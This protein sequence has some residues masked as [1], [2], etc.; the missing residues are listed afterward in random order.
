MSNR[1]GYW[2]NSS[3]LA[4]AGDRDPVEIITQ[5]A[6]TIVLNFAEEGNAGPPFDPFA[7]AE[8]LKIS[9][10]PREDIRDARTIHATGGKFVIEF[11]PNQPRGR[12]RY[13][14]AH[15]IIHT[16][17]PDCHE[18]VRN[19]ATH[20]AMKDDE[21]Q[22]EM[23]CNIG[24]A[25]L[26]MP[27][28][29]F[30]DLEEQSLSIDK[31]LELRKKY[32]VSTEAL[33]LRF[34]KLTKNACCV[35]SASRKESE[36]DHYQID[37][38]IT[39]KSFRTALPSGL[40]LPKTSV[41]RECTAIGFTAKAVESWVLALGKLNVECVGIPPY[42]GKQYPRV[43][44]VIRSDKER[45]SYERKLT[46][47]KGD[48]MMPRGGDNRIIAHIVNDKTPRWGAGFG[49]EIRKKWP[50]VQEDFLSWASLHGAALSLGDLHLSKVDS[51]LSVA[52]MICQH[53]YGPSAKPRIRYKA[54]K[55]CLDKL[56][57]IAVKHNASIHMPRIG[58]GQAGGS[59]TVVWELIDEALCQR[60]INVT[61]YDLPNSQPR[62]EPQLGFD[63]SGMK[64]A[65]E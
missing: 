6:R 1:V 7:I 44:G 24:A 50:F 55:T 43:M 42:P 36:T 4:L 48:A 33:L 53:G 20:E 16:L 38:A 27:I 17:F 29:S 30:P 11:N 52:H 28:G 41:V 18:R 10:V 65:Y 59:W 26:L 54:V 23:V 46:Y 63:F 37:Y 8:F 3:I 2:I 35:F 12:V 31:L 13:S 14:I 39:S 40:T 64:S 21:W 56:G 9:V 57:E 60:G 5:K 32:D 47:L 51:S 19:R 49:L 62:E 22:L 61:V 15:E 25:E 34:A 58:C 45:L